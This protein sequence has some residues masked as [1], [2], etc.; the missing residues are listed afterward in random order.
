MLFTE[1]EIMPEP[2]GGMANFS[3]WVATHYS[4]PQ[5]AIDAGVKGKII[6]SFIV[7]ANGNLSTF[8]VVQDLG[9]GTGEALVNVLKT[10]D[11]WKPGIQN[12]RK[13]R[14]LFHLPMTLDLTP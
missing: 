10:A 2:T 12:G 6:I 1:T 3:K 14:V 9:H 8:N 11:A 13:V 5:S 7:D 4:Y